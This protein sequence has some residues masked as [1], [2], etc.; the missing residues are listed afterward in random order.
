V[1]IN[2]FNIRWARIILPPPETNPPL[3]VDPYGILPFP[4]SLENFQAIGVERRKVSQ[5]FGG[6]ENAQAFFGLAPERLPS[7][8][9]LAGR[10]SF[11]VSVTVAPYQSASLTLMIDE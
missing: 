9:P 3:P 5:R 6:L 4:I 11:R 7:T 10:K 8:N 2:N 1:I